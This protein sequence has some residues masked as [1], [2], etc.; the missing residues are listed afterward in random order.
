MSRWRTEI[1][2]FTSLVDISILIAPV[3]SMWA[4]R[5]HILGREEIR[6][7][8]RK[9]RPAS[10][11]TSY[12]AGGARKSWSL[13]PIAAAERACGSSAAQQEAALELERLEGRVWKALQMVDSTTLYRALP[14]RAW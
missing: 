11:P 7:W 12:E 9:T 5:R 3:V 4:C 2:M 1:N 8:L 10:R 13:S 14:G 6:A